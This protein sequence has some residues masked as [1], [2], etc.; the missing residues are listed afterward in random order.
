MSKRFRVSIVLD[1]RE[2]SANFVDEA[3]ITST[4]AT[5]AKSVT[6]LMVGEEWVVKR[7]DDRDDGKE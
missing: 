4:L 7:I 6:V 2:T 5:M 3:E 1:G